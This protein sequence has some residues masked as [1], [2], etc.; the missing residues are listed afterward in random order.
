M[1][2]PPGNF[3]SVLLNISAVRINKFTQ[4]SLN[5]PGWVT[6]PVPPNTGNGRG[7]SPG[8]LQI[9]MEQNQTGAT[10]F[11]LGGVPPSTYATVQIVVDPNNPGTIIPACQSTNVN[12]EGCVGYPLAFQ[13]PSQGIVINLPTVIPVSKGGTAALV[14][15]LSLD[16]LA[17]PPANNGFFTVNVTGSQANP[18]SFMATVSGTVHTSG[19]RSGVHLIPLQVSAEIS[20]TNNVIESAPVNKGQYVLQLPAFPVEGTTYDLFASGGSFT[21]DVAANPMTLHPGNQASLDFSVSGQ[22]S[23]ALSGTIADACTGLG[24]SGA[25]VEL[26][27]PRSG[28][29]P[30]PAPSPSFCE[31]SPQDCIVVATTSTDQAGKYPLP[32]TIQIPSTF[33]Q[34]PTGNQGLALLSSASGYSNSLNGATAMGAGGQSCHNSSSAKDCSFSLGTSFISGTV[35]LTASPP[36]SSSVQVQVFAENSGTNQL[37]GA[38]SSP[39]VFTNQVTTLPFTLNVPVSMGNFDLFAAAID[40]YLGFPQPF[41]GHD[42]QVVAAVPGAAQC[43]TSGTVAAIPPLD[44]TGHGSITGVVNNGSLGTAVEV[45]KN[46]V[47]L[48]GTSPNLFSSNAPPNNAYTL[49]VPPD[50]YTLQRSDNGTPVATQTVTVPVPAATSTPCPSTCSSDSDQT[51]CPGICNA[52]QA[53]PL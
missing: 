30:S 18:Q 51:M 35:S 17:A 41:P 40:P 4:A 25:T 46:G 7:S 31:T 33:A 15:Q 53:N 48:L 9:D 52:T 34:L 10:F 23:G 44:C 2:P 43:A 1:V 45:I 3:R 42:I 22:T 50:T 19:A 21:Y 12:Q 6:I 47:Q 38:L 49:C 29:M 27:A 16:I 13:N 14:I 24:I 5:G 32:G 36:P 28:T 26:L 20:G 37:V 11:N 8:D 39:L